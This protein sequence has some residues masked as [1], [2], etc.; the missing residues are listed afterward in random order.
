MT[1]DE[2]AAPL[3][4]VVVMGVSGSGK[5][6][7]GEAL[8]ATLE[9]PF[10][11]ADGLHPPANV[12]LMAAGTPL[13]DEDRWPWLDAVGA[14]LARR[15]VVVACSAL[16]RI[17]R[18]RLREFAPNVVFVHLDGPAALLSSR[19]THRVGHFM[20]AALLESQLAT[21]EPPGPDEHALVFTIADSPE[22]IVE[23]AARAL[24]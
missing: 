2:T 5:S 10:V 14:V 1:S 4:P 13:R 8:A 23:V 7:I 24:G 16:R 20:P 22:S 3:R 18:D 17:Y 12:A 15:P 11:D 9:L 21:L 6:T 19:V